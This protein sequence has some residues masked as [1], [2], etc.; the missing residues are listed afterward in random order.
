MRFHCLFMN[1]RYVLYELKLF[2]MFK[3]SFNSIKLNIKNKLLYAFIL[4]N[5]SLLF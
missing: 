4:L 3:I 1:I 5:D 2:N